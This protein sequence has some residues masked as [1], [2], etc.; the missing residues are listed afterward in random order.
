VSGDTWSRR[1]GIGA[2][3]PERKEAA[4]VERMEEDRPGW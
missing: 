4:V 3:N 2:N 1:G